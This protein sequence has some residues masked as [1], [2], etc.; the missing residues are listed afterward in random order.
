MPCCSW[1]PRRDPCSFGNC[2]VREL[3]Q[4]ELEIDAIPFE[5]EDFPRHPAV[6]M[7]STTNMR[8]CGNSHAS[9][10]CFTCALVSRRSA[11]E[12]ALGGI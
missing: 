3:D 4:A 11:G 7:A 10:N 9:R 5:A 8:I 2:R 1:G 6:A 12:G